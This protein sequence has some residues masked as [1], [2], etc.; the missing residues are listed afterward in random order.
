MSPV[1]VASVLA[2]VAVL[3]V[4]GVRG[5]SAHRVRARLVSH[6]RPSVAPWAAPLERWLAPRLRAADFDRT[7]GEVARWWL[8]ATAVVPLLAVVLGPVAAVLAAATLAAGPPVA[9]ASAAGRRDDRVEREL[10][11]LLEAVARSLRAGSSLPV[12][13]G[14]AAAVPTSAAAADLAEVLVAVGGGVPLAEA[15]EGWVRIR[16]L[17]AVRLAVGA[18]VLAL[19]AGGTPASALDGVAA[20]LR[21]RHEVDR[22]V[23][24]LATQARTSAL[25]VTLAPLAF[26][27]L[28]LLGDERTA[29]FL[30]TT[31][32]GLGCLVGGLTLDGLGAWWMAHLTA[33]RPASGAADLGAQ[34]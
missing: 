33:T 12:A 27:G 34:R 16:P 20:T 1:V 22:E 2:L 29:A 14:D 3:A 28:G 21:E 10:G 13:L 4:G 23:R 11:G 19:A 5:R 6:Q 18:L 8:A 24:A 26:G 7:P 15:L 32:W 17:P 9:L 25:V 30:L 31:P